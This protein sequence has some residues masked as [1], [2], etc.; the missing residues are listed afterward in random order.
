MFLDLKLLLRMHP[1]RLLSYLKMRSSIFSISFLGPL[2]YAIFAS[3]LQ[4]IIDDVVINKISAYQNYTQVSILS[5]E[6]SF[7]TMLH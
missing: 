1:E 7:L 4:E 5:T 6:W 3:E 2:C